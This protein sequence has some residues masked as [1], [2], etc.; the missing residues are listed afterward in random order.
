MQEAVLEMIETYITNHQE[1]IPIYR[2]LSNIGAM[3]IGGEAPGV[4]GPKVVVG[5]GWYGLGGRTE[6]GNGGEGGGNRDRR[7]RG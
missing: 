5:T 3:S 6:G 1:K 4:M 7:D 2:Y